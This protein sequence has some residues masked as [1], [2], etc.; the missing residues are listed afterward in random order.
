MHL[1]LEQE[2]LGN[3]VLP[4]FN[5]YD[6]L[7]IMRSTGRLFTMTNRSTE[8]KEA[9]A[10]LHLPLEPFDSPDFALV[11]NQTLDSLKILKR[12]LTD[13]YESKSNEDA[14]AHPDHE[15]VDVIETWINSISGTPF[16]WKQFV[17]W[18]SMVPGAFMARLKACCPPALEILSHWCIIMKQA[19]LRW[20]LQPW[21]DRTLKFASD[22]IE[23]HGQNSQQS[24]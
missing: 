17:T 15:A 4:Q 23:M 22:A 14:L 24:I 6:M 12:R 3:T 1:I 11:K 2:S 16:I 19:P 13:T 10:A 18:P 8:V 5:P 20:Y 21:F 7:S 9:W